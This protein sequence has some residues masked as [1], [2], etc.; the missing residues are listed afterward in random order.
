MADGL[1]LNLKGNF[2]I[3]VA[4]KIVS[5]KRITENCWRVVL[6][7]PQISSEVRPG[8][9]IHMKVG[10]ENGPIFRRPF[11][12][13]RRVPLKGSHL[14]IEIVYKVIGTGTRVMTGLRKGDTVDIIGPLGHGFELDRNKS[15]Q[16]VMAGG[17]GAA[18]LFL[19]AEEISK[20]GLQLKVLLGAEIKASVL[21][22]KEYAALNGEVMVS[23][24]DGAYGFHGFV[25]QMLDRAF[26][27]GKISTDCVVYSSGPEPMLKALAS[28]CQ[29]YHIP[30]QVSV[31]RHMMCGIGACL[32]CVCRVDP[33]HISKNRDLESSHIQFVS[34]KEFGYALVCKDGPVFDIN[35]VIFDD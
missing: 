30:A 18:C 29:K 3:Q 9:F 33:N 19:L 32:A 28:I 34:G 13:F 22:K 17:T 21:L 15:V 25:T 26:Q 7:S 11:S 20:A 31:E 16:V 23:T 5:N 12:V 4:S 10:G 24:D 35:E 14:G 6:D 8:Q 2:M 1:I 27:E